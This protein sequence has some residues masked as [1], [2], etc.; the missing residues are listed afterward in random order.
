MGCCLLGSYLRGGHKDGARFAKGRGGLDQTLGE[1][2]VRKCKIE[3]SVI[4]RE[5]MSSE[6]LLCV[7]SRLPTLPFEK[8]GG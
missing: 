4:G 8:S 6:L 7:S 5:Q 2:E 3:M 1:K